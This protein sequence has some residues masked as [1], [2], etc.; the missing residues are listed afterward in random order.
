MEELKCPKCGG[1]EIEYTERVIASR[2]VVDRKLSALR[3]D[4]FAEVHDWSGSRPEFEC[5]SKVLPEQGG[6]H[7]CG[8]SW[9]VPQE[10]RD[11]IEFV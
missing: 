7:L 1:V 10:L 6:I 4:G 3:V 5:F 9:P 2:R 8:H 11:K